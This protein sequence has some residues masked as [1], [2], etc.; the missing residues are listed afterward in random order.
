MSSP[1]YKRILLKL[2]GEVLQGEKGYGIDPK[3]LSFMAEEIK[4]TKEIGAEIAIIIGGGNIF[5]GLSA[6]AEAGMDRSAADYMG[7]L[8]TVMNSI[9]L[10]DI[11][12]KLGIPTRVQTAIEI[13]K[14]AEP[15]IRRR[16]IRHIE[17]GRIVIFAGGTGN[18]FFST[19]TAASLRAVEI[20]ADILLKATKVDGVYTKDPL[21]DPDA[22]KFDE[23]TYLEILNQNLKIMDVT[24]ISLCKENSLPIIVF[25]LMKEDNIKKVV[26]GEKIGTLIH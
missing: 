5:R 21:K 20:G 15:Y 14:V 17:K 6:V 11:L 24:A 4:K 19:D 12:E 3:V 23:I 10:Q 26:L 1:K 9:A 8:A 25:D 22:K 16:A 13:Q 2:S 7:M 18:P